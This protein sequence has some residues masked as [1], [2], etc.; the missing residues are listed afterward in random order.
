MN[1]PT[2]KRIRKQICSAASKPC[3][4]HILSARC[5]TL[6]VIG[7]P[8]SKRRVLNF[9]PQHSRN[10]PRLYLHHG[11][12]TRAAAA[13]T[14]DRSKIREKRVTSTALSAQQRLAQKLHA[15]AVQL[16][17]KA[18][19]NAGALAIFILCFEAACRLKTSRD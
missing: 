13:A 11:M 8:P 12:T 10:C 15:M 2:V 17:A 19:A 7:H 6:S 18:C 3:N 5:T 9:L 14:N 16:A 1:L 4:N